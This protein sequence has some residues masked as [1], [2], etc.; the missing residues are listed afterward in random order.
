MPVKKDEKEFTEIIK[1]N[2]AELNKRNYFL[3]YSRL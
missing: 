1:A 3:F 2:I